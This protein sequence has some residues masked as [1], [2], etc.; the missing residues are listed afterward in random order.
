MSTITVSPAPPEKIEPPR[1]IG[2]EHFVNRELSWLEFNARVLEEA[3]DDTNPLLERLKFLSI[4]SSNLDEFMMVRVSGVRSQMQGLADPEDRLPEQLSIHEQFQQVHARTHALVSR[5]YACLKDHVLPKLAEAGIRLVSPS[6]LSG[7]QKAFIDEYFQQTVFP[8]L[9]PMAIDPSHPTPHLRSRGLYLAAIIEQKAYRPGAPKKLLAV[10]QLPTVLPRLIRVPGEADQFILLEQVVASR[11]GQL[12]GGSE[13]LCWTSM[14]ITRDADL[15]IDGDQVLHDLSEAVEEGLKALRHRE[16]V[17]LEIAAGTNEKLLDQIRRPLGILAPE[18]YEI[19]GP[20]DL[21]AFTDWYANLDRYPQL[22]D[23]PFTPR[24][25]P[26]LEEGADVFRTIRKRDVLIHHPYESFQCVVDF[27]HAAAED[28]DVLAI[29]QTLYRAG[30]E[31]PVIR[32]LINAA[33]KGK[34]VTAVVELLA[35]FDEQ[36][37]VKWARQMERAGV[38][39][40]YGFV[41]LKTHCKVTLV[42]RREGEKLRRYVHVGTGNYNSATA[43]IYTDFGL[44]TRRRKFGEDATALFNFLTSYSY[45][46]T[47]QRFTVSPQDLQ[48]RILELIARETERARSGA[49]GRIIAKLNA[50][51]DPE[52]IEALYRASQAGVPID[53]LIRGSCCLRPGIPGISETIRVLSI[54][55]RFLE[56]SRVYVFG[57]GDDADVLLASAYWMPRNF[58]RRVELMFPLIEPMLKRRMLHRILPTLLADNVKAREMQADGTYHRVEREPAA[59]LLRAQLKFLTDA[60]TVDFENEVPD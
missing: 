57:Q 3:E 47:W 12:F 42:V 33:E 14:R 35:R 28:P 19:D 37:N 10:V 2:P 29:K 45:G 38:H 8:V 23:E 4:F 32:A 50:L 16:V 27:L 30:S 11:L 22:R 43:R 15:D 5:Q 7:E 55:D 18:L 46:H 49:G 24:R 13:I 59:P 56:H 31:S 9:T 34:N 17:R 21:T 60:Q 6:E 20:L 1:A 36:S 51:V 40:V 25:P 44:F 52:V 26:G 58:R 53:L 48:R 39:V 54:L 41:N